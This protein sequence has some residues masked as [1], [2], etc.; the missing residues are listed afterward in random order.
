MPSH[1]LREFI[2]SATRKFLANVATDLNSRDMIPNND[3][4]ARTLSYLE[5]FNI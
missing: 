4:L 2:V 1:K 3:E 5:L